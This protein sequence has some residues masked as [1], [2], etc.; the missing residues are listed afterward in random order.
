MRIEANPYAYLSHHGASPLVRLHLAA[1][2]GA[3]S[4]DTDARPFNTVFAP[5]FAPEGLADRVLAV[6]RSA[7]VP[8]RAQDWWIGPSARPH[9][10]PQ[11]L[12]ALGFTAL[13][14]VQMMR[15]RL[16]GEAQV[17][18]TRTGA[19][20]RPVEGLGA[21]ADFVA[22]HSAA[23]GASR[24]TARFFHRVLASLP[25]TA[26]GPLWHVV[27]RADGRPV[28]V[29]SVFLRD[30]VAG[31]YNVATVPQARGRG[32]GTEAA[33]TALAGAYER[34][35]RTAVL[36]AEPGAAGMYRTLGFTDAG[37]LHRMRC[38]SKA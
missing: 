5:D 32:F 36:G 6:R 16:T 34:G 20:A 38:A 19:R 26:G 33:R 3:L 15:A 7:A 11:R 9:D 18:R 17:P 23:Y 35:A 30:G 4:A 25:H 37:L 29:A 12:A 28:A 27:L 10:L 14:P 21:L 22:V 24:G 31:L 2:C 13:A 1:D 8:G